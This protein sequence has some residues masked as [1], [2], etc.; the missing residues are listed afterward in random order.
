MDFFS[1]VSYIFENLDCSIQIQTSQIDISKMVKLK[2]L[3][4]QPLLFF[5]F[6]HHS[7][8][9]SFFLNHENL[10]ALKRQKISENILM[11]KPVSRQKIVLEF[12]SF[13][14]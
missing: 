7:V 6:F 3:P 9:P 13:F 5:Y 12:S 8:S 14:E 4:S 1:F 11:F 10:S 2:L